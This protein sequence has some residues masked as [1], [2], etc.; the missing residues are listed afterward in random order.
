MRKEEKN[1]E[2]FMSQR[3]GSQKGLVRVRYLGPRPKKKIVVVVKVRGIAMPMARDVR[4]L[5]AFSCLVKVVAVVVVVGL[6]EMGWSLL[7]R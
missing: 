6:G 5:L 7:S 4:A 3:G 1:V 2:K